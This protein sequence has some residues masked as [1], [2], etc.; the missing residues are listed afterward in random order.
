MKEV[1]YGTDETEGQGIKSV[2]PSL[3]DGFVSRMQ[4]EH[5]SLLDLVC[6]VA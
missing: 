2:H 3:T 6:L 4:S 5:T 1:E